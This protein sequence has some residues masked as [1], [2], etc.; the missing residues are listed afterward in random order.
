MPTP[1][2]GKFFG[3]LKCINTPAMIVAATVTV[4]MI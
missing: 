3:S 4:A 2:L 1:I